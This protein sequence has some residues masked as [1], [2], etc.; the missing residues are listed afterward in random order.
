MLRAVDLAGRIHQLAPLRL[1]LADFHAA[2]R[3]PVPYYAFYAY[4][5]LEDIGYM[6]G[7]VKVEKKGERPDWGAMNAAFKTEEEHWDLLTDA[8]TLAR[9][10]NMQKLQDLAVMD[11][12]KLLTLSHEAINR[13]IEHVGSI[14]GQTS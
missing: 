13:A 4:R 2:R 12:Q 3:E 8:G 10:L 1:A 9:H 7:T 11:P 14:A 6:F 5:V